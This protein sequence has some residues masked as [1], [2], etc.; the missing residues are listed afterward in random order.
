MAKKKAIG[1]PSKEGDCLVVAGRN[2][3][4][5]DRLGDDRN[6]PLSKALRR[7]GATSGSLRLVHAFVTGRG[8]I[9]GFRYVH[10][11]VEIGDHVY[12]YSNGR[13]VEMAKEV[14]YA[15]GNVKP[16]DS[17]QYRAY[18]QYETIKKITHDRT[19][20]PWDLKMQ[21]EKLSHGSKYDEGVS[22]DAV[23]IFPSRRGRIGRKG[24]H[25][26]NDELV[27]LKN[28]VTYG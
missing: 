6:E 23:R 21:H 19:W 25:L 9:D 18:T 13:K 12:D 27:A 5:Y 28:E 2:V 10:A 15:L 11:W 24:V 14:Y 8:P 4:F 1:E 22:D 16:N 20:G 3:A 17:G 26:T 7:D